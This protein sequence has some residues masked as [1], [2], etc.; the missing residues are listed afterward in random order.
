MVLGLPK[1]KVVF[2]VRTGTLL[3]CLLLA[4]AGCKAQTPNDAQLDRR[5]EVQVRSQFN[6]P[7]NVDVKLG[8]RSKSDVPG[9]DKLPV[10]LSQGAHTSTVEFLIS[11]DGKTLARFEKF[12]ISKDPSD[13]V[14]VANRPERGAAGAKVIIVNFDDL[15]CPYCAQMHHELFPA[16]LDH[17]K[18]LVK[19]VYKDY[20]L[21]ELHPWA[22][23]AAIDANCLAEQ[24]QNAYWTYVDYLH[25]HGQDVTGPDRDVAKSSATLDKLARDEGERDKLDTTK[26]NACVNKQDASTVQT[27]MK[28][29]DKLGVT[30]T[31][32]LFVN[33]ERLEGWKPQDQL[34]EAIDRA[35]KAEG[36][37]PPPAEA[38]PAPTKSDSTPSEK[39]APTGTK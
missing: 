36:V 30:G 39:T 35:L 6:I 9:Y 24:N 14:S 3:C 7:S 2:L 33:G 12:D 18:G 38:A 11:Q 1:G 16:T 15:E 4:I 28:E 27:Y 22:L 19:I 25:T 37:Q 17:Y 8:T 10:M 29:G 23:H 31:P 32:T 34:W 26:L 13:I 5:I 21:V 20:P